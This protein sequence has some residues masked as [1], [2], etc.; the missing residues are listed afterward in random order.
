MNIADTIKAEILAKSCKEFYKLYK[1]GKIKELGEALKGT[2]ALLKDWE[3]S[4]AK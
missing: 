4:D 2:V 1:K 3:E